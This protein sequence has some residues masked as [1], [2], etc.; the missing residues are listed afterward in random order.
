MANV[1]FCNEHLSVFFM[2]ECYIGKPQVGPSEGE[3]P[4]RGRRQVLSRR[5]KWSGKDNVARERARERER[6]G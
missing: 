4:E 1:S 2:A 6:E 3:S 5:K